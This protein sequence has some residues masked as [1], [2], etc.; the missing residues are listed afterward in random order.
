MSSMACS[1]SGQ[2][3]SGLAFMSFWSVWRSMTHM[4]SMFTS[5]GPIG[6]GM[7]LLVL[8][9]SIWVRGF[10]WRRTD[11]SWISC[12]EIALRTMG[13]IRGKIDSISA[14]VD[15]SGTLRDGFWAADKVEGEEMS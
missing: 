13:R 15:A 2:R 12:L 11:P 9:M 8:S 10:S 5:M 7:V 14:D 6:R 4:F 1:A 3:N